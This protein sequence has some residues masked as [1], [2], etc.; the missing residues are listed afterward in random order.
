M[1]FAMAKKLDPAKELTTW[2]DIAYSNM[3]QNEAVLRLLVR[4]GIVTKEE[5]LNESEEV[6]QIMQAKLSAGDGFEN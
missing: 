2:E 5:F 6:H 4:K 3:V 1:R